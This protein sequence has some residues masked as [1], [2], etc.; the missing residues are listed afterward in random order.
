M[1]VSEAKLEANRRNAQKSTGP[2]TEEGKKNSSLNAT[3]HGLRA[4]TLVLRDED[5]QVLEERRAAWRACLL[6]GDDVEER[7]VDDAVVHTW[8]QDRARRAQAGRINANIANYGIDQGQTNAKAVEDLGRRLFKDRQ[9]PLVFY[10]SPSLTDRYDFSRDPSTSFA[11]KGK[12]DDDR[13]RPAVLVLSL[14]STLLGCEWMLGEWAKLKAILDQGQP[15][16]SSDKLKAVRLLGKQPFDTID[17]RDTAMV[18]MASFVLKPDKE[19]WLWEISTELSNN[20]KK[21]FRNCAAVRELDSLKPED[22]AKAREALRRIIERAVE[23]LT[24]KAET[25]RE[26]ARLLAAAAPDL[27]AF[28]DSP[29]GERLRR[30]DLASGRGLARS[31]AELRRHR[32]EAKKVSGPLLSVVSDPLSVVSDTAEARDAAGR[33]AETHSPSIVANPHQPDAQAR[34]STDQMTRDAHYQ[35]D[36]Q[37]REPEVNHALKVQGLGPSLVRRVGV[38]AAVPDVTLSG[39]FPDGG[40]PIE[41]TGTHEITTNEANVG[42]LSVVRGPLPMVGCAVEEVGERNVTNEPTGARENE[43]NEPKFVAE[44]VGGQAVELSAGAD[45]EGEKAIEEG[46]SVEQSES[47]RLGC[48]KIGLARA[49]SLRKLNEEARKEAEQAMAIRRSRLREQRNK[50]G[51]P[52]DPPKRRDA[53]NGQTR[54]KEPAGRNK[55]EL[56]KLTDMVLELHKQIHRPRT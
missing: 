32:R 16:L 50:N 56:D 9:G 40:S 39:E 51:K 5:P 31:L 23:R 43:T 1:A 14:Q 18:F 47:I 29:D 30:F 15:W 35:P 38:G 3:K 25:H 28:D 6:P 22:A 37:A 19:S 12:E 49:E 7:L 53:S 13:D 52:A 41:P 42:P 55:K 36:A 33:L 24:K 48:E 20:D 17:D 27:L 54:K 34:I 21:R 46:F 8:L 26:R 10:P 11:G 4:E 44:S 2:R 45:D